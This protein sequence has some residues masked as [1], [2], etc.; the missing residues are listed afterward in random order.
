MTAIS[1]TARGSRPAASHAVGDAG[2]DGAERCDQ[3]G[4]AIVRRA[5]AS[6]SG[7][8]AARSSHGV[9]P[10]MVVL[11]EVRDVEV[12]VEVE[13]GVARPLR[14]RRR[15]GGAGSFGRGCAGV[16]GAGRRGGA[17]C[18]PGRGRRARLAAGSRRMSTFLYGSWPLSKPAAMTVT[19]T[20]SP[21]VSSMT[22]PKMMLASG[23]AASAT[24]VAASLISNRPRSEPP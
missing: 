20:S 3:L 9:G 5:V 11:Q 24:S 14:D 19:R 16:A 13:R 7:V 2:P 8:A 10:S 4:P 21:R 17:G 15:V 12:V 6:S 1:V 23:W 22:A 18:G